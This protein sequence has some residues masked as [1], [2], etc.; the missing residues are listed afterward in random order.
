MLLTGTFTI[1]GTVGS[2]VDLVST[3]YSNV[4]LSAPSEYPA[5]EWTLQR[6]DSLQVFLS[7]ASAPTSGY[8]VPGSSGSVS[9]FSFEQGDTPYLINNT[10]TGSTWYYV[11]VT[12]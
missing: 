6:A 4:G 9:Q 2:Y 7:A 12:S 8:P 11:L 3:A 1:F 10:N 5:Q